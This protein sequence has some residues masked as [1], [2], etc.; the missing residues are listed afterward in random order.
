MRMHGH[1]ITITDY[2]LY[3]KLFVWKLNIVFF[4]CFLQ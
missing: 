3:S 1:N 2:I 4:H